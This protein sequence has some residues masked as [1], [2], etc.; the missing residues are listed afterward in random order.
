I[1]LSRIPNMAF[2]K[3]GIHAK[4][5]IMF[6]EMWSPHLSPAISHDRL[7]EFYEQIV[8]PSL[9]DINHPHISHW[10]GSYGSAEMQARDRHGQYHFKNVELSALEIGRFVRKM[11]ASMEGIREFRNAFFYHEVRGAKGGT[12]HNPHDN[13][14]AKRVLKETF[15]H[16]DFTKISNADLAHRWYVDVAIEVEHPGH[17]V[18]WKDE[19]HAEILQHAMPHASAAGITSLIAN[20][21]F[22]RDACVQLSDISGFRVP[23]TIIG[24]ADGVKYVNV[25]CTEKEMHYQLHVGQWRKV[26]P[27]ELLP[28]NMGG[29]LD[30]I[31]KWTEVL[32]D[33]SGGTGHPAQPASARYEVRVAANK[34]GA[35]LRDVPYEMLT[36]A[37]VSIPAR[38]WW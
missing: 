27:S 7:V 34:C 31:N 20:R 37:C 18:H 6:P 15:K 22:L 38:R 24:R 33:N 16:L 4:T 13:D 28:G 10:P 32:F 23:T 9:R 26:T 17:V 8:L 19:F 5:N 30:R 1:E 25:Y 29:L 14:D 2:A 11:K 3:V 35:A 36:K 21:N 12:H